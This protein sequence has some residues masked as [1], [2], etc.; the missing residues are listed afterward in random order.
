MSAMTLSRKPTSSM[1]LVTGSPQHFPAFH[2]Y[3]AFFATGSGVSTLEIR[4]PSG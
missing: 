3:C 2:P 4:V 1:C